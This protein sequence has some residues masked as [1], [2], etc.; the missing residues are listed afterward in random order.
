MSFAL[1]PKIENVI[2]ILILY[3]WISFEITL[4]CILES[5]SVVLYAW[6]K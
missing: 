6:E 3:M 2:E 1:V 4:L 5:S